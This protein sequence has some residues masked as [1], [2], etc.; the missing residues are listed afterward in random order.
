MIFGLKINYDK[1][2]LVG[3]RLA[4]SDNQLMADLFGCKVGT[5][6]LKYLGLPLCVGIPK[7]SMW[8]PVV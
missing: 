5:L 4:T 3:I 6:P 8:D 7:R 2:E 1:C